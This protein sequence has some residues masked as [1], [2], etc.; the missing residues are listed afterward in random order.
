MYESSDRSIVITPSKIYDVKDKKIVGWVQFHK[1]AGISFNTL[2]KEKEF[3]VHVASEYDYRYNSEKREEIIGVL[4][5][6]VFKSL[7][8][9]VPIFEIEDMDLKGCTTTEKDNEQFIN[10]FPF[11][12]LRINKAIKGEEPAFLQQDESKTYKVMLDEESFR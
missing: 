8:K 3:T 12:K 5:N 10:R 1:I 4:E 7:K 9:K 6:E 11:P 2:G